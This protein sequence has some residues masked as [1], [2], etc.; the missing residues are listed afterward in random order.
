MEI[1]GCRKMV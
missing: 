1:K